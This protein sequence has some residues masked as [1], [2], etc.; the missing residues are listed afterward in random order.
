MRLTSYTDYSLR[1]L[2]YLGLQEHRLATIGEIAETYG[3]SAN[4]LMKIVHN[5]GKLGYIDTI[6]GRTGGI[7]LAGEPKEVNL[8]Q[9]VRQIEP[10]FAIVDCFDPLRRHEC[11]ISPACH[12]QIVFDK[13]VR[14]FLEVLDQHTLADLVQNPTR[15]KSLLQIE[16]VE[17]S[18]G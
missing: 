2:I 12:L 6:R 11:V 4:H 8:G 7:K 18:P 10:D 13:A 3:I 1:V 16:P 15:L 9:L 14:A 17:R 5:L